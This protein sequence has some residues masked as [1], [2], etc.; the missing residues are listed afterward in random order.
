MIQETPIR[1][2]AQWLQLR[3]KDVTAS[4]VGG[5]LG[6]HPYATP[7]S[8]WALKTG[9]DP[10]D[11]EE[12][13]AMRRGRLLEP[14]AVQMLKED[15]PEL[16]FRLPGVYLR[17]P[18][19]R[20]GA[21]PDLYCQCP[22][23]GFGIVQ[24]KTTF[25]LMLRDEWT[26]PDT[27]EIVPPAWIIA[28]T[29][30]EATLSGAQWAAVAVLVLGYAGS[31][32]LHMVEIPI[33]PQIYTRIRDAVVAFWKMV[34]SGE[35]PEADPERDGPTLD[36]V[37]RE[38]VD[39]EKDLSEDPDVIPICQSYLAAGAREKLA[40]EDKKVAAN[41]LK[42]KMGNAAN[43]LLPNGSILTW[44]TVRKAGGYVAPSSYRQIR[45]P[46]KVATYDPNA[47]PDEPGA[48]PQGGF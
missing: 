4:I 15:Y 36:R 24:I 29:I 43:A 42:M 8:I 17:D 45:V 39:I 2:R 22:E 48:T 13:E 26:D 1:G 37:Y 11:P 47:V 46:A 12:N 16:S 33:R 23:R 35:E 30:T 6:V 9:R 27:G 7:Y 25:D 40:A 34:E 19:V 10:Q 44:A 3:E 38:A 32:K 14:V 28:Q 41:K 21:T 5:L 31:L 20:I 18:D